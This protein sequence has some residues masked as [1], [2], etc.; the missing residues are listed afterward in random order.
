MTF[1][2]SVFGSKEN[3]GVY[4]ARCLL[5]TYDSLSNASMRCFALSALIEPGQTTMMHELGSMLA[6]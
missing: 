1:Y 6:A 3:R 2:L 4:T 5:Y